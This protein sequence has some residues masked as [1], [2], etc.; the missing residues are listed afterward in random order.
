M[1]KIAA[2]GAGNIGIMAAKALELSP[3]MELCGFVRREIKP[4]RGFEH[5]PVVK[6]IFDLPK[7]PDGAV[8]CVPSRQVKA[9]E[10]ELLEAGIFT[11]DVFDIHDEIA[12]LKR[13]LLPSAE[14]GK[15]S[16]VIGAGW[17]PGLDSVIRTLMLAALPQGITYTDFGPGMSMGHSAAIKEQTGIS[18]A[19]SFTL[20]LGYGRHLRKIYAVLKDGADKSEVEHAILNDKYFEHDEC[21]IE[22]VSSTEPY[23][24]VGHS[25][26]INRFGSACGVGGNGFSFNLSVNNPAVTAQLLV[27][28]MRAAFRQKPGV[29]S[30]PE[31]PPCDFCA[32]GWEEFI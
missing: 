31:I 26:K 11:A 14:E 24:N 1:K 22:F 17:D 2:I 9:T 23:F 13:C 19:V 6:S 4:V 21:S 18:D 12:E 29:Y 3:D 28:A 16:A 27:S 30:M 20:P 5:V 7:K 25:A 15:S 32:G 10:K 8:I